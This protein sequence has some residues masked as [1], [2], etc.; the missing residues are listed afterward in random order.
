MRRI[1]DLLFFLALLP[2][3]ALAQTAIV[4]RNV[5]LRPAPSTVRDPSAE[6]TPGSHI[7]L[8]QPDPTGGYYD[9]QTADAKTGYVWGR[10]IRISTETT[11]SKPAQAV[12]PLGNINEIPT[13]LLA[14]GHPVTR[15]FVFKFNSLVFPGWDELSY[16]CSK[17]ARHILLGLNRPIKDLFLAS[18]VCRSLGMAKILV[19]CSDGTGNQFASV[20]KFYK[21]A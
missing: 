2:G 21:M 3:S 20:A 15:W 14:R 19:V 8:L 6:L 4:T 1:L 16:T 12:G 5:N 10:N 9:V 18:Y 7:Q 13:P 17:V 11:I